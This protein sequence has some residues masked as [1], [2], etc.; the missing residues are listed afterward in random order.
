MGNFFSTVLAKLGVVNGN[1][2]INALPCQTEEFR[3]GLSIYLGEIN[4]SCA[5]AIIVT[6]IQRVGS[7]ISVHRVTKHCWK[8]NCRPECVHYEAENGAFL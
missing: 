1:E 7:A 4:H 3:D 2:V 6:M 8:H 5:F